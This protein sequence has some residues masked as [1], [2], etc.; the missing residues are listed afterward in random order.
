MNAPYTVAHLPAIEDGAKR[1]VLEG[2]TAHFAAD[3]L[4]SALTGCA[5]Q[6]YAPGAHPGLGHR[7]ADAE[8]VYVVVDGSGRIKLDDEIVDLRRLDAVR[9]APQVWRA[10][11]AGP[12]GMEVLAFGPRHEGDG[13]GVAGWWPDDR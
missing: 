4:G 6:C 9:V 5:L 8:E 10:F 2:Q 1:F 11:S 13:E 12:D 3:A 7:H